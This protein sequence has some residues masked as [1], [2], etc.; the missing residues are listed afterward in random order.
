MGSKK[1][2]FFIARALR[3]TPRKAYFHII[4]YQT[5]NII[6]SYLYSLSLEGGDVDYLVSQVGFFGG[7]IF[8]S[9]I[10]NILVMIL[11][12]YTCSGWV[13]VFNIIIQVTISA[14]TLTQDLGTDLINH[15][16]YNILFL[17]ILSIP[18]VLIF[19]LYKACGSIKMIIKSWLW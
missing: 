5:L 8:S 16:Q 10:L 17:V 19:L 9:M 14:Y 13:R 3:H 1:F 6:S 15:G 18:M 11:N 4:I 2:D 12:F 7:L